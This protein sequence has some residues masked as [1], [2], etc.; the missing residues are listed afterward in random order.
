M[1]EI[2]HLSSPRLSEDHHLGRIVAAA[3]ADAGFWLMVKEREMERQ[4][5]RAEAEAAGGGRNEIDKPAT[6][7]LTPTITELAED[8]VSRMFGT[9][10]PEVLMI[11]QQALLDAARVELSAVR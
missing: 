3:K 6:A 5:I 10:P 9:C 11:V 7:R 4:A 1:G 2:R 8:L